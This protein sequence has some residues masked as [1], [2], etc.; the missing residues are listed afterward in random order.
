MFPLCGKRGKRFVRTRTAEGGEV[1]AG[2]SERAQVHRLGN[3][4]LGTLGMVYQVIVSL[5][6]LICE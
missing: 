2:R 1:M 6:G 3:H 4:V 5:E